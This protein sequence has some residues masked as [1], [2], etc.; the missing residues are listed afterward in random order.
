MRFI[1]Y[2]LVGVLC[3]FIAAAT[4]VFVA[5]PTGA[6]RDRMIEAVHE[7]TGRDLI[8]AGATSFTVYPSI[9]ISLG[10]VSLSNPPGMA[11]GSFVKMASLEAA[12]PLLPLLRGEIAVDRFVLTRPVIALAVDSNGSRSWDLSLGASEPPALEADAATPASDAAATVDAPAAPT[13]GIAGQAGTSLPSSLRL[14]DVRIVDGTLSYSDERSGTR[15]E[16]TAINVA[17]TLDDLSAPLAAEGSL[18]ARGEKLPFKARITS[19]AALLAGQPSDASISLA[20]S[21]LTAGFEGKLEIAAAFTAT[22]RIEAEAASL[23]RLAK[24]ASGADLPRGDTFG[25]MRI[26]AELAYTPG[27]AALTGLKLALDGSNATGDLTVTTSG[28]RPHLQADLQ[29]DR[30]ALA[31]YLGTAKAGK[32]RKGEAAAAKS[33]PGDATAEVEAATSESAAILASPGSEPIVEQPAAK[34]WSREPIDLSGLRSA[35][36]DATF[37]VGLLSYQDLEASDSQFIVTL[38]DGLLKARVP[39]AKLYE[40]RGVAGITVDGRATAP[41][42]DANFSVTGVSAL[43]MLKAAAAFDWLAGRAEISIGVKGFGRSLAEIVRSLVGQGRFNIADGAIVGVDIAKMARGLTEG[44]FG[45]LQR[46]PNQTTDFS[47]LSGSFTMNAGIARNEDLQMLGPL[48]R[49]TGAGSLDLPQRSLDYLARPKVVASLEGQGGTDSS[50]IE[51]PV[52]I[53]GSFDDPKLTPDLA[54]VLSDPG[55]AL[56]TVQKLAKKAKGSGKIGAALDKLT[57]DPNAKK[58]LKGL[59]DNVLGGSGEAEAVEGQ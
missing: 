41:K 37:A 50:G 14:G 40:G 44:R 2:G 4:F 24:W 57:K 13:Q 58:K 46:Q 30:L 5:A 32:K 11:A 51:V 1:V 59:L 10:D 23:R 12:I 43:P 52:R 19:I 7:R 29:V 8:V 49:M 27:R 34:G 38:K 6:I 25:A 36:A 18:V 26:E 54:G 53:T 33:E 21:R 22:G 35:D 56:D 17:L 20:S 45:D 9:G 16:L 55:A 47:A 31:R 15:E 39:K 28:A 42:I 48:V 3:V